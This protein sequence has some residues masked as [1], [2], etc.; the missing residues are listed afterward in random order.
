[1]KITKIDAHW[2]CV[3]VLIWSK[4]TLF[5][6][7]HTSHNVW[8]GQLFL[9]NIKLIIIIFY[10][11]SRHPPCGM[12]SSFAY[13]KETYFVYPKVCRKYV[14]W[15]QDLLEMLMFHES[16]AFIKH[17]LDTQK[18]EFRLPNACFMRAGLVGNVDV[19]W[20]SCLHKT[21]FD[22]SKVW[23]WTTESMFYESRTW[24]KCLCFMKV[25]PS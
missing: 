20:K 25:L 10:K 11:A 12:L 7:M 4:S 22:C 18:C 17:T 13:D 3:F 23:V 5:R 1:M 8:R 6:L 14:L 24:W 9:H 19:S 16:H 21:Y 2:Q 15:G